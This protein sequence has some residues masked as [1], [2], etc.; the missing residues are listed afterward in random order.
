V[1]RTV[2]NHLP[3]LV[4]SGATQAV[5]LGS[6]VLLSQFFHWRSVRR[7]LATRDLIGG[8]TSRFES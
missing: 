6:L 2:V 4:S 5:V 7:Y 3:T 1:F 8:S